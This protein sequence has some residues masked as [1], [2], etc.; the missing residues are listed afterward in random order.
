MAGDTPELSDDDENLSITMTVDGEAAGSL[1]PRNEMVADILETPRGRREWQE[2]KDSAERVQLRE[3]LQE[4]EEKCSELEEDRA[5]CVAAHEDENS[6]L[7]AEVVPF[8]LLFV[9]YFS[10]CTSR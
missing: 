9:P 8:R 3:R 2:F 7:R 1:T 6:R 4:L 10:L 5:R